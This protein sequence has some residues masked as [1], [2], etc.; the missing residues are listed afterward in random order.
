MYRRVPPC[1]VQVQGSTYW[2]VLVC[3]VLGITYVGT[4]WYV[5]FWGFSYG[6]VSIK[7]RTG[8]YQYIPP[9]TALYQVYRIP[10]GVN[11]AACPLPTWTCRQLLLVLAPSHTRKYRLGDIPW[12]L[13]ELT[14]S[15][16]RF[17]YILIYHVTMTSYIWARDIRLWG[18]HP[19]LGRAPGS[20]A[21]GIRIVSWS[22]VRPGIYHDQVYVWH[23]PNSESYICQVYIWNIPPCQK[24]WFHWF[25]CMYPFHRS[26]ALVNWSL[27]RREIIR[28]ASE[29]TVLKSL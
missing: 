12:R 5:P 22:Y 8:S 13:W 18:F 27:Q 2:Y 10:D 17:S 9:C 3:T 6:H 4:Y 1:T 14:R 11:C 21:S 7:V 16:A 26:C 24:L 23:I 19:C 20:A 28:S 25:Q 15:E 29:G